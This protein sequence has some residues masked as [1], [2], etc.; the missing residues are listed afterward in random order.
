MAPR[1]FPAFRSF[2]AAFLPRRRTQASLILFPAFFSSSVRG[3]LRTGGAGAGLPP[4]F[5]SNSSRYC[6]SELEREGRP[7]DLD[8]GVTYRFFLVNV[9]YRFPGHLCSGPV[10]HCPQSGQ[11]LPAPKRLSSG[12]FLGPE[13][14][15]RGE[16]LA[17]RLGSLGGPGLERGPLQSRQYAWPCPSFLCSSYFPISRPHISHLGIFLSLISSLL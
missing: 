5:A 16:G 13:L 15:L 10:T 3:F 1:A 17:G 7:R 8:G 12:F 11:C 9:M 6:A 2:P 14:T 4:S